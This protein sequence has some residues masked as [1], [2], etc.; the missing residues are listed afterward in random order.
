MA[1]YKSVILGSDTASMQETATAFSNRHLGVGT[2]RHTL[3][4]L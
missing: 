3:A 1:D 4:A 2:K